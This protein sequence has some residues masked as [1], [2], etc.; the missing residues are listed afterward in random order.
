RYING[1]V[2]DNSTGNP[3]ADAIVTANSTLSTITNATGFYSF[4]VVTG[5]YNLIARND[6]AYYTNDTVSVSTSGVAVVNQDVRLQLKPTGTITG[7][8]RNV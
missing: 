1:T 8:V 2:R 7:T 6:P 3:I 5:T 4:A